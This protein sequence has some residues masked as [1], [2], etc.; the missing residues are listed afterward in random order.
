VRAIFEAA[1]VCKKDGVDVH[2]EIMVPL[3]GT[4]AELKDQEA[5]I[6]KIATEVRAL[7]ASVSAH[8]VSV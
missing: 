3:V 7:I 5:L 1:A 2:P 4:V 6:K 8:N